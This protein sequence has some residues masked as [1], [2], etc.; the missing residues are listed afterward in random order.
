MRRYDIREEYLALEE[1]MERLVR[2]YEDAFFIF[3]F[4][5]HDWLEPTHSAWKGDLCGMLTEKII[6]RNIGERVHAPAQSNTTYYQEIQARYAFGKSVGE[7]GDYWKELIQ[8][9]KVHRLRTLLG[10]LTI[11]YDVIMPYAKEEMVAFDKENCR[12]Y[13]ELLPTLKPYREHRARIKATMQIIKTTL[14]VLALLN[15]SDNEEE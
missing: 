13:P 14:D 6:G 10:C 3:W 1:S 12:D 9:E 15:V 2:D 8:G 5:I 11:Y 4:D 7:L